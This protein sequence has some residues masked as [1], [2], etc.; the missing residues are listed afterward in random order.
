MPILRVARF[1]LVTP[2]GRAMFRTD[3]SRRDH[4]YTIGLGLALRGRVFAFPRQPSYKRGEKAHHR[5][6]R[7]RDVRVGV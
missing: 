7:K 4:H 1:G 2:N 5:P 6:G 3:Y